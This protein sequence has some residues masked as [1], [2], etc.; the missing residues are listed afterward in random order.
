LGSLPL[1]EL[2]SLRKASALHREGKFVEAAR[3]FSLCSVYFEKASLFFWAALS[4]ENEGKNLLSGFKSQRKSERS[5]E[6]CIDGRSALL[7]AAENYGLEAQVHEKCR[8]VFL[9]ERARSDKSWC[10]ARVKELA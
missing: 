6:Q 10:E 5:S 9:A 7:E 4:R 8:C 3:G 2:E 1:A